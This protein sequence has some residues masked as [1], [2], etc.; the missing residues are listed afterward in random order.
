MAELTSQQLELARHALGL[1]NKDRRSYRNR[2]LISRAGKKHA[3]WEGMRRAGFARV[4]REATSYGDL[5]FL[6]RKGAEAALQPGE[7]LCPE[8]FPVRALQEKA[9]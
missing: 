2:Y 7:T 9:E 8:D 1:P 4:E 3:A 5:F 6:T